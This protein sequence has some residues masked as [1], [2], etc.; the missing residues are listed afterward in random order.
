MTVDD[1][2]AFCR[3]AREVIE[4]TTG[5]HLVGEAA[6]GESALALAGEVEPDL[7]LIDVRMPGMD[8]VETARRLSAASPR[9][10]IVLVSTEYA[11]DLPPGMESCG[12]AAYLPKAEFGTA[13]LRRLWAEHGRPSV[14]AAGK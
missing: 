6:C 2:V 4:A 3:A 10:T 13:A 12:A 11:D 9:S 8:G 14:P 7:V 5:F 1:Q